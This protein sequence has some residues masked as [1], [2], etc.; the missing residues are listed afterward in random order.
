MRVLILHSDVAP[1]APPDELDTLDTVAAVEEALKSRGHAVSLA[2]FHPTPKAFRATLAQARPDVVFN[3]T[4]SVFG[5]GQFAPIACQ[6]LEMAGVP[7]TGNLG[8]AMTATSDKPMTKTLLRV[9]G[10]PTADWTEGPEWSGIEEGRRY[11]VKHA[12]EDAST[13]LDDDAIVVGRDAV[14]ARAEYCAAKHGGRWFAETFVEGREFNIAML[15]EDG[16][17][18]VLP[19]AEMRFEDWPEGR[20]KIVGYTAKWAEDAHEYINTIRRF[21]LDAREP[22]LANALR[23]CCTRAWKLF[24][25][26]G[27]VRIDFRVD[28][29][30][31]PVILEINTN[32]GF[33]PHAG[34]AAAAREAGFDYADT[35]ER[36][37]Q[38]A[39][40]RHAR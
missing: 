18:R 7:F 1:D 17:P 11:I 12:T 9:A 33:E 26:A 32:P 31:N 22:M 30:G 2:A 13:G 40:R 19:L 25:L 38:A 6:M 14:M 20:P 28:Q 27:Y 15:E 3:L 4:E 36:L 39:L 16:E 37:L 5:L 29:L 21:G 10:L 35:V 24:G 8:A 23:E 34:Y